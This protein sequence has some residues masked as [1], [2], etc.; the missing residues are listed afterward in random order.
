MF[1]D[2]VSP[3]WTHSPLWIL[4]L[5]TVFV[6][7][8]LCIFTTVILSC[9]EGAGTVQ[10]MLCVAKCQMFHQKQ[11]DEPS[12]LMSCQ[13]TVHRPF[14]KLLFF[15]RM[16]KQRSTRASSINSLKVFVVCHH[17]QPIIDP[18]CRRFASICPIFIALS[19]V[20]KYL[21]ISTCPITRVHRV[22]FP[23]NSAFPILDS[24]KLAHN[25]YYV[26]YIITTHVNYA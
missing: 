1:N 24:D 4:L 2:S 21:K 10:S 13:Q 7:Y 25:N 11:P 5:S 3:P 19:S 22:E 20:L 23:S 26:L 17:Q 14:I 16:E 18:S 9:F 8:F 6:L 12:P 15:A